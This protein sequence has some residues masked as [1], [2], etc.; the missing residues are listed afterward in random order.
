[1]IPASVTE[2]NSPLL[3]ANLGTVSIL[4]QPNQ[5]I[6]R[7]HPNSEELLYKTF[8][9]VMTSLSLRTFILRRSENTIIENFNVQ[10]A[11]DVCVTSQ[12]NLA[13]SRLSFK[14]PNLKVT[15]SPSMLNNLLCV[16]N[17]IL[18]GIS[19]GN[20]NLKQIQKNLEDEV[21]EVSF[22]NFK[23]SLSLKVDLDN[24]PDQL[25]FRGYFFISKL[26]VYLSHD[27]VDLHPFVSFN[28]EDFEAQI[29][30]TSFQS[31][32]AVQLNSIKIENLLS[33]IPESFIFKTSMN[34]KPTSNI[35]MKYTSISK[36]IK[37]QNLL[38]FLIH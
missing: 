29:K 10:F 27:G 36:V 7:T 1:M 22:S 2:E 21:P 11:L 12:P 8:N 6:L 3:V 38:I 4:C 31:D 16:F 33:P 13:R 23:Q 19:E 14:L 15:L 34:D 28:F 9:V 25:N 26:A 32:I 18:S 17:S 20:E 37:L 30:N 35:Y 5:E 24:S